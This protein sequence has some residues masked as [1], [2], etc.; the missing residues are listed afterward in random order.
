M[1]GGKIRWQR[2]VTNHR[3]KGILSMKTPI[4]QHHNIVSTGMGPGE[5]E[6]EWQTLSYPRN[7]HVRVLNFSRI[8]NFAKGKA[9][10]EKHGLQFPSKDWVAMY[11][12]K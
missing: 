5:F 11:G 12:N 9:F 8:V 7:A 2:W 10:A 3:S 4:Q 1:K 6:I